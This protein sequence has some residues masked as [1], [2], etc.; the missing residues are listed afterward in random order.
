MLSLSDQKRV[1]SLELQ[2]A[3]GEHG[4]LAHKKLVLQRQLIAASIEMKGHAR[5]VRCAQ[6]IKEI[7]EIIPGIVAAGRR[8]HAIRLELDP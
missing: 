5:Q 7:R 4:A 1:L 8:A 6:L 2:R 3:R